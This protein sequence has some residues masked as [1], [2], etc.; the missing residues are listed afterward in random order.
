MFERKANNKQKY[1]TH[2][3]SPKK[4]TLATFLQIS[5]ILAGHYEY[6]IS[7][8]MIFPMAHGLWKLNSFIHYYI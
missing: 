5:T 8:D 2:P 6:D 1:K 7:N 3:P 4:T